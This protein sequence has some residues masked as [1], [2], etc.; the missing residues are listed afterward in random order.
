[1]LAMADQN[2]VVNASAPGLAAMA[3]VGFESVIKALQCFEAPDEYSRSTEFEGRRIQKVDGGWLILNYQKYREIRNEEKRR[4]QNR[5]AQQK[6]RDSRA[7]GSTVSK[8]VSKRKQ[9]KPQSAQAEAEA[10]AEYKKKVPN[11]TKEKASGDDPGH[12]RDVTIENPAASESVLL[13][14]IEAEVVTSPEIEPTEAPWTEMPWWEFCELFEAKLVQNLRSARGYA[15]FDPP[16]ERLDDLLVK[17]RGFGADDDA[18]EA[19]VLGFVERAD[20]R[21]QKTPEYKDP[22]R[23]LRTWAESRRTDWQRRKSSGPKAGMVDVYGD[24]AKLLDA[25]RNR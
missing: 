18:I 1:M 6:F 19:L 10:E 12:D 24:G 13:E 20:R 4:E 21:R 16:R 5:I 15:D 9:N 11:G 8:S 14:V 2:G 7:A 25:V 23:V 22:L 3:Q 17:L